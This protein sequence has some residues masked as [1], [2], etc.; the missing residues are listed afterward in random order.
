MFCG[1]QGSALKQ[2]VSGGGTVAETPTDF[3]KPVQQILLNLFFSLLNCEKVSSQYIQLTGVLTSQENR[4]GWNCS[5]EF[6]QLV[7]EA[8]ESTGGYVS[9]FE[10]FCTAYSMLAVF[11]T[12]VGREEDNRR[13]G[14]FL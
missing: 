13:A 10:T 5:V 8:A 11:S 3:F 12:P 4:Q 7:L 14:G 9:G 6:Q 1:F 2:A